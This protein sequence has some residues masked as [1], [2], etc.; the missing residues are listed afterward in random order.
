MKFR[1]KRKRVK[2][3]FKMDVQ[4]GHSLRG[5]RAKKFAKTFQYSS[6]I[7][8]VT[9]LIKKKNHSKWMWL[10]KSLEEKGFNYLPLLPCFSS[11]LSAER[12]VWD[13][14]KLTELFVI[15]PEEAKSMCKYSL[16]QKDKQMLYASA[17][18]LPGLP[19]Y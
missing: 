14:T 3:K 17:I 1:K 9:F 16:W 7:L 4:R 11:P 12:K 13:P 19:A 5:V 8:L 2:H 18:T 15:N 6:S 10:T